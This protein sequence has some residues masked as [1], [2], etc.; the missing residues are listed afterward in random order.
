ML[1]QY[2]AN[3]SARRLRGCPRNT[4]TAGS[5]W[6]GS[7]RSGAAFRSREPNAWTAAVLRNE[8]DASGLKCR[9]D[10]SNCF[11]FEPVA[12]FETRDR[13]RSDLRCFGQFSHPPSKSYPCH[14]T[15]DGVNFITW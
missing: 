3:P 15:L 10:R 12:F 4:E 7:G 5:R 14:L 9:A 11:C 13:L 2:P 6:G 8:L 1:F